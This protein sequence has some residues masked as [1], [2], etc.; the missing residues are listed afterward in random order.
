MKARALIECTIDIANPT[1]ELAAVI[2]AVLGSIP[3][4]QREA[5]LRSL[6][7]E[8]GVALAEFE[9]KEVAA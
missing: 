7:E 6:D 5:V 4:A 2:S 9:T 3:E 1:A 8:I